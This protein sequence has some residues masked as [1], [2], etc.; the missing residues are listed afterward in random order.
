MGRTGWLCTNINVIMRYRVWFF[1]NTSVIRYTRWL[2][3]NTSVI[4]RYKR[5]VFSNINVIMRYRGWLL[6]NTGVIVRY[7]GWYFNVTSSFLISCHSKNI[8]HKAKYIYKTYISHEFY[9]HGL[10]F[11]HYVST[12][13]INGRTSV[14]IKFSQ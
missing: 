13:E 3:T 14:S 7:K 1:T 2:F 6:T 4:M 5:W 12:A 11:P 8:L 9:S 10:R